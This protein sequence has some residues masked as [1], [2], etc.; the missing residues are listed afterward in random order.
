MKLLGNYKSRLTEFHYQELLSLIKDAIILGDYS[1][2]RTIDNTTIVK[3]ISQAQ[4]FKDLPLPTAGQRTTE[5]AFNSPIDILTAR[6]NALDSEVSDLQTRISNLIAILSKDSILLDQILAAANLEQYADSKPVLTGAKKIKWDF[7]IGYGVTSTTITNTDPVSNV[8][9]STRPIIKNIFP[10]NASAYGGLVP[11]EISKQIPVKDMVWTFTTTGQ[12]EVLYGDDWTKLSILNEAPL[13]NFVPSPAINVITPINGSVDN[14]FK[15]SGVPTSGTVPVFLRI[16]FNPRRNQVSIVTY[17]ALLN[18]DFESGST[19]WTLGSGWSVVSSGAHSGVKSLQKTNSGSGTA[20]SSAIVD[21]ASNIFTC[22]AGQVLFLK[23]YVNSSGGADGVAQFRFNFYDSTDTFITSAGLASVQ[24]P[25]TYTLVSGMVTVPQIQGIVKTKVEVVMASH[26]TGTWNFD[27]L[28]VHTPMSMSPYQISEDTTNLVSFKTGTTVINTVYF[29]DET[30]FVDELGQLT[31][32]DIPDNLALT[33]RFTELFPGYQC[34]INEIDWSPLIMLDPSRPYKDQETEFPSLGIINNT[35][36]ITDETGVPIGIYFSLIGIPTFEYYVKVSTTANSN[37]GATATLAISLLQPSYINALELAPF[38]T[39]PLKLTQIQTEG[40]TSDTKQLIFNGSSFLDVSTRITFST[41][42]VRKL[43]LT[44]YQENYV[45][46]E[47]VI[48][49]GDKLRRDTI[50]NLQTVLPIQIQA[51]QKETIQTFRGAQYE[52]GLENI[53][54]LF[55]TSSLPSVFIS[56]PHLIN[57]APDILRFDADINGTVDIY[58]CFRALD[59]SGGVQDLNLQG[60]KLVPNSCIGFPFAQSLTK[61]NVA[62][63]EIYL[64][65][66]LRSANACVNRFLLQGI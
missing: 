7:G 58:L 22:T 3:L 15:F 55:T 14:I 5:E 45:F 54:S 27:D 64:K 24:P 47:H 51:A 33:A 20:V 21:Q 18:P 39:L 12:S 35:F 25:T 6:F 63:T 11:A 17:N 34:S 46:K 50:A 4:D 49:T 2:S 37:Y 8:V 19:S 30:Y 31:I 59:A 1:G 29:E 10:T 41:Q 13:V 66:V 40:F 36:P 16:L 65:I 56:G 9:Y 48:D 60:I 32:L 53:T 52:F 61:A 57:H 62:S 38:S 26:T 44:F 28:V 42:L 23:G 43:Y